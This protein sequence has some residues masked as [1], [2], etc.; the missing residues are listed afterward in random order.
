MNYENASNLFSKINIKLTDI[1]FEQFNSYEELLIDWNEKV[2]LTAIT[3]DYDIWLKHFIDSCTINKYIT[4]N[5]TLIDVGTGAGFPSL[6]NKIIDTSIKLTLLDS[7]NKRINILKDIC[8]KLNLN[9][10]DF[11]HNRAEDLGNDIK[12]REM[13]DFATARAVANLS[14]LCEYCLPLVKVGGYFI[15]MKGSNCDEEIENAKSAIKTL[16]AQIKSIERI[17]LPSSDNERTIIIIEKISTTP[18]EYPRKVNIIVKKP[19]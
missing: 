8:E 15:C 16:G 5:S 9:N 19:L 1:Q 2:N 3:D 6:P 17:T 14:T 7:L 13:F 4:S 11:D 12:Y 10:I 18:L